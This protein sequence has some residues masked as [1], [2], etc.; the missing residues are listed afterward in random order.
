MKSAWLGAMRGL[1]EP[2]VTVT[3]NVNL[4][5]VLDEAL[6]IL[7]DVL[8]TCEKPWEENPLM[9]QNFQVKGGRK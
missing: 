1:A 2:T 5:K 4:L 6:S 9:V 8:A 3:V 7:P